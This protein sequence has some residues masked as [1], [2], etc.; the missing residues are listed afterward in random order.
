[1]QP[2]SAGKLILRWQIFIRRLR[3][4]EK[5][6]PTFDELNTV[7]CTLG[8]LLEQ[9]KT[10]AGQSRTSLRMSIDQAWDD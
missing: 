3:G 6:S 8:D 5:L 9:F 2:L 7:S 1:M 10:T 4:H